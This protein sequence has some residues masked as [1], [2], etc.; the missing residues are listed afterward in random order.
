MY[1]KN[2]VYKNILDVFWPPTGIGGHLRQLMAILSN[3]EMRLMTKA[4]FGLLGLQL[5]TRGLTILLV[6]RDSLTN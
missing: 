3:S 4:V 1:P 2:N 6:L 5:T